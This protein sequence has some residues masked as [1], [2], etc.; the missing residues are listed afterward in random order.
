M[1]N[2]LSSTKGKLGKVPEKMKNRRKLKRLIQVGAIAGIVFALSF[3]VIWQAYQLNTPPDNGIESVSIPSFSETSYLDANGSMWLQI[4]LSCETM[5]A[6]I[7]Y[8]L[9]GSEPTQSTMLYSTPLLLNS[10]T[11]LKARAFKIGMNPSEI[12]TFECNVWN[13][14]GMET[15]SAPSF[16]ETSYFDENGSIWLQIGLNC[17]TV[18][19][20][21]YYTLNGNTPTNLTFLYSTPLLLNSNTTIKARA[22]K[23]GWIPSAITLLECNPWVPPKNTPQNLNFSDEDGSPYEIS[24]IVSITPPA[25]ES[26]ITSYVLYL[27]PTGASKG[28]KIGEVSVGAGNSIPIPENTSTTTNRF[29]VV[30]SKNAWGEMATG[31]SLRIVDMV[32]FIWTGP[33]SI[34]DD[35][36]ITVNVVS[37]YD[38]IL[39]KLIVKDL[40]IT[41]TYDEDLDVQLHSPYLSSCLLFN[42][43]GGAGD[44]FTYTTFDNDATINITDG[45]PPFTGTYRPEGDLS[46]FYNGS[47]G[48]GTWILRVEDL[49]SGDTGVLWSWG[50][51]MYALL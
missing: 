12:T 42:G 26:D 15:V 7:F 35:D 1:I 28:M 20:L 9:N 31:R 17:T 24:G 36:V 23:D 46:K 10:N 5:G 51:R 18:G 41:H 14:G 47:S 38:E 45:T 16:S 39:T 19:A 29:L 3:I 48:I 2:N 49:V 50:L 11:T 37:T 32:D 44:D 30:V 22:F 21:I 8:T 25:N 34:P 33:I 6:Q 40:N 13:A 43:V 4:A 27:S